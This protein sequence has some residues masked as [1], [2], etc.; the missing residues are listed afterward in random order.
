[1]RP[2]RGDDE[3]V[4]PALEQP[5]HE[6]ILAGG[7]HRRIAEE[8]DIPGALGTLLRPADDLR[9]IRIED[10]GDEQAYRVRPTRGEPAGERMRAITESAHR[11]SDLL[12]R[13]RLHACGPVGDARDRR[14]GD[15]GGSG[16]L[17]DARVLHASAPDR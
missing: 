6:E 7:A 4:D 2:R 5:A 13:Q 15:A 8:H 1:G 16:D 11:G 9:E 12:L 3:T 14:D 10:V 17:E